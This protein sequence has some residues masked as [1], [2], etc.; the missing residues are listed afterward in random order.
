MRDRIGYDLT[1][2]NGIWNSRPVNQG[3]ARWIGAEAE[4][5]RDGKFGDLRYQMRWHAYA[6]WS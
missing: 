2:T 5:N 1:Q 3:S 6:N 4:L